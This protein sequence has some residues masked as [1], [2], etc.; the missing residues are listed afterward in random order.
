MQTSDF[1][2][3]TP[4]DVLSHNDFIFALCSFIDAFKRSDDKYTIISHPPNSD[5]NENENACI[6]AAAVHKLA[7]DFNINVPEWVHNP[8]YVMPYPVFAFNTQ[9]KD[10]QEFLIKDTPIEF[11]SKN[12]FHGANAIVRV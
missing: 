10:Y 12:I 1:Q 2:N 4:T 5:T 11:A 8:I 3:I 9:N 6:L 7:N